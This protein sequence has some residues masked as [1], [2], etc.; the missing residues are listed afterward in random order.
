MDEFVIVPLNNGEY[1]NFLLCLT[2]ESIVNYLKA[3]ENKSEISQKN[4]I[5]L[6]DQLLV[7][8]NNDNRFFCCSYNNGVINLQSAKRVVP[9][10]RYR[11]LA[12]EYLKLNFS[13]LN[14][15]ILTETQRICVMEGI[16]F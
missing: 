9:D 6:V 5:M 1:D 11:E 7:T 16:P 10:L 15:S 14:N 3:I 13:L 2:F 12:V 4:G 8:G